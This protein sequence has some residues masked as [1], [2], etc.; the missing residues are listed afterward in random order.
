MVISEVSVMNSG[1][2]AEAARHLHRNG[3]NYISDICDIRQ[4][5][6]VDEVD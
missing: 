1:T 4:T 6:T 5:T 3:A 2:G